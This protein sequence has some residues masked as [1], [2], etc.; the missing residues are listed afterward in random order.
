MSSNA[1]LWSLFCPYLLQQLM[2]G[3]NGLEEHHNLFKLHSA[4]LEKKSKEEA[5]EEVKCSFRLSDH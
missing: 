2:A 5:R 3:A 4:R 1:L